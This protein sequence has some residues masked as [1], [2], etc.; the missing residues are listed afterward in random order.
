[1]VIARRNPCRQLLKRCGFPGDPIT[2]DRHSRFG[3]AVS[4][5]GRRSGASDAAMR[6]AVPAPPAGEAP[7][8]SASK[9]GWG[10]PIG[11]W[12]PDRPVALCLAL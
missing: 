5:R 10:C 2:L 9:R 12:P 1:M 7:I 8:P 11:L 4:F 6:I 3:G